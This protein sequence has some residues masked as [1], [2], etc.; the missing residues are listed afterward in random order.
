MFLQCRCGQ[1][2]KTG[3]GHHVV[4]REVIRTETD[5]EGS[6]VEDLIDAGIY[7]SRECAADALMG[8]PAHDPYANAVIG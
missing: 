6:L 1:E 2:I 4:V 7:C 3:S 8:R 5:I